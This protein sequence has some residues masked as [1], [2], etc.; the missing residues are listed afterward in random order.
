[1]S[2]IVGAACQ[3]LK[4][5]IDQASAIIHGAEAVLDQSEIDHLLAD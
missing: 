5:L 4:K 3:G 1:M 2:H